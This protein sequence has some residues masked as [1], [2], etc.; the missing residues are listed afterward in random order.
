MESLSLVVYTFVTPP[1]SDGQVLCSGHIGGSSWT[2]LVTKQNWTLR[3]WEKDWGG[4]VVDTG[5][6]R[7]R[8]D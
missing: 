4:G 6:N 5:I 3:V 1:D 2:K 8:V 7:R